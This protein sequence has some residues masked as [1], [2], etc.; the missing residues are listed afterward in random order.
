MAE[1]R[2]CSLCGEGLENAPAIHDVAL[3]EKTELLNGRTTIKKLK[4]S[5]D[6]WKD[7]WFRY[8]ELVGR[9]AWEHLNC[10]H[11]VK[12]VADPEPNVWLHPGEAFVRIGKLVYAREAAG[13]KLVGWGKDEEAANAVVRL[14]SL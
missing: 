3:C 10:P 4:S 2:V 11:E 13:W 14:M 5:V 8:R 1:K 12:L 9:M 7:A 6:D